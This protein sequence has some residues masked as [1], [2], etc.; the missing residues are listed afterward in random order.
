MS[1]RL[2]MRPRLAALL[3]CGVCGADRD[4]SRAASDRFSLIMEL[5]AGDIRWSQLSIYELCPCCGQRQYGVGQPLRVRA[6]RHLR[7]Q[8]LRACLSCKGLRRSFH[9]Q[10]CEVGFSPSCSGC[11]GL[12]RV[13]I[14]RTAAAG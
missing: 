1:M 14:I 6:W 3:I 12:G 10:G 9:V 4:S 7:R 2:E 13:P 8:G 11:D 5:M